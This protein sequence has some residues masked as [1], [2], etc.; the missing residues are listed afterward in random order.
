[1]SSHALMQFYCKSILNLEGSAKLTLWNI[2][3]TCHA[4]RWSQN[5]LQDRRTVAREKGEEDSR[6]PCR[7]IEKRAPD[8]FQSS[9][10]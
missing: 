4:A 7:N 2:G 8:R 1:M 9:P 3:L 6:S 5:R 10:R